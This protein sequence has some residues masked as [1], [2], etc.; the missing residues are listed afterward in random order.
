MSGTA[1]CTSPEASAGFLL[2]LKSLSFCWESDSHPTEKVVQVFSHGSRG[3]IPRVNT[4]LGFKLG[5]LSCGSQFPS[6]SAF[7]VV[8]SRSSCVQST[9][10]CCLQIRRHDILSC[11]LFFLFDS[12]LTSAFLLQPLL[13]N[14]PQTSEM[15]NLGMWLKRKQ[16][17]LF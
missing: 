2:A 5:G 14:A 12:K 17:Y 4:G 15:E 10:I 9:M 16:Q 6:H 11:K 8:G 7:P 1:L 3:S 13:Y